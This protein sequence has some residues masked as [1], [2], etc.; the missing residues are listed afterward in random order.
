VHISKRPIR[1]TRKRV[2][3]VT[4]HCGSTKRCIGVVRLTIARAGRHV[5]LGSTRFAI[6]ARETAQVRVSLS[7]KSY[8]LVRKLHRAKGLVNVRQRDSAGHI[9]IGNRRTLL[10]VQHSNPSG[11]PENARPQW[12]SRSPDTKDGRA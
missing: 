5:R 1:V 7:E 3:P 9:R 8:R 10:T 2:A 12:L 4:M 11:Q 6:R